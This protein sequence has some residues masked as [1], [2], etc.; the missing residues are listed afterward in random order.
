MVALEVAI[1]TLV[2]MLF[3]AQD[4]LSHLY[5]APPSSPSEP[6]LHALSTCSIWM[7]LTPACIWLVE[8]VPL[9]RRR[10]GRFPAVHLPASIAFALVHFDLAVYGIIAGG[11]LAYG[12]YVKYHDREAQLARA[13]LYALKAQLRPHFLFN[14]LN[15]ISSLVRDEPLKAE[16]M[17]SRLGDLLRIT[18]RDHRADEVP[19]ADE[20]AFIDGYL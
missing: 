14:T 17:L 1:W 11:M 20:L 4:Y 6:V 3:A 16:T 5:R 12:Y 2:T 9:S 8:R 7:L 19:L 10:A 18:L 15:T 13:E